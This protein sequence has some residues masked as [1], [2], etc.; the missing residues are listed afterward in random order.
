MV[1]HCS[2]SLCGWY[3]KI[4]NRTT[5]REPSPTDYTRIRIGD[6][7][8]IRRGQFNFLFSAAFPE[9]DVPSAS[10]PLIIGKTTFRQPRVPGCLRTDTVREIGAGLGATVPTPL[11]VLSPRLFPTRLKNVPPRPLGPGAHFSFELTGHHGA[12]LMTRYPT[13]REDAR[14]ESVF[15][16]YT[17]R[18]YESWVAFAR[19][20]GEGD[21]V[22]PILVSGFDMAK[23]FAVVAYSNEGVS[24][25]ADLEIAVPT[26]ASASAFIRVTRR[27]R[28]SPRFNC[29]PQPWNLPPTRLAID[30]P[31]WQPADARSIPDEFNQCVFI[32]YYTA[33]LRKWM[34]PKVIRAGAGPHDLG[35]GNNGGD[36]YPELTVRS[37]AEP[38]ISGDENLEGRSDPTTG[39]ADYES[40]T[41]VRN[42]P[43]V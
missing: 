43:S 4:R 5:S 13:F 33:R 11:Y 20:N 19:Q 35:S 22:R 17:K 37:D 30:L 10:D 1:A 16:K 31:S 21:N 39:A 24:V 7:G 3:L 14:L 29:G 28:C 38:T 15:E 42:T 25:E 12:V 23:D 36:A 8:Y 32:R 6:V 18:H 2:F 41:V 27:T 9:G 34:V 40:V 26:L